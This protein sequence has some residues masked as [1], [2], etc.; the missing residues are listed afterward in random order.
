MMM[1]MITMSIDDKIIIRDGDGLTAVTYRE[2]VTDR[3]VLLPMATT[4][5]GGYSD[6]SASTW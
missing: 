4:D 6:S 2:A 1:M 3:V 5:H